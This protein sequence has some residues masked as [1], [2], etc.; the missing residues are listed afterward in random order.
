VTNAEWRLNA[1]QCRNKGMPV[2]DPTN[3]RSTG[4]AVTDYFLK[5]DFSQLAGV[6]HITENTY[7]GEMATDHDFMEMWWE[8]E[9]G[10]RDSNLTAYYS[11]PFVYDPHLDLDGDGWSNFAEAR[12][13]SWHGGFIADLI[14]SYLL[15]RDEDHILHYPQPAIGVNVTYNGKGDYTSKT[16]VVR[17]RTKA[18][19]RVD[20][21]LVAEGYEQTNSSN[22]GG[23]GSQLIGLY[24]GATT[25]HGFMNPGYIIPSTSVAF[26]FRPVVSETLYHWHCTECS[27]SG[28]TLYATYNAHVLLHEKGNEETGE[29][30]VVL[31]STS[32]G[33]DYQRFA[34]SE[35]LA[36]ARTGRVLLESA[37]TT[38]KVYI[39]TINYITGEYSLDLAKA[40]ENGCDLKDTVLRVSWTFQRGQIWPQT[41]WLSQPVSTYATGL[42]KEGK[43]II[44][45]FIDL[46][47]NNLWDE[48]EPYGM[49]K[50]VEI[51]WH[52]TGEAIDI[53]LRDESPIMKRTPVTFGSTGDSQSSFTTAKVAVRRTAINGVS[54]GLPVRTLCSTTAISD[55]RAYITE[56]DVITAARPDLDWAWLARDAERNS[57]T[58]N[59]ATYE[60]VRID[61][62]DDGT[63]SNVVLSAFTREFHLKPAV[64][65]AL[66]PVQS[67]L[68]YAARPTFT[69]ASDDDTMAAYRLQVA[70]SESPDDVI[71]D[72]GTVMLPG[73]ISYTIENGATYRVSPELYVDTFATTNSTPCL[74]DGSNYV[75][76]VALLNSKFNKVDP[77]DSARWSP[78]SVFMMDVRNKKPNPDVQTGYGNAAAAVR[79]YGAGTV[80]DTTT[81]ITNIIVEAYA[82]ADFTGI[83][84]ARMR[85]ENLDLL[86]SATDVT[87]TNVVLRGLP[88]GETFL[89]AFVDSNNNCR[90]DKFES[91]G[92]ANYVGEDTKFI[93]KPKAI[94]VTNI[95]SQFP[96]ISIFIEDTDI[97]QNEFVDIL[98]FSAISIDEE[99]SD[100][101][102][103]GLKDAEEDNYAADAAMWDTDGDGMPDGWEALYAKLDPTLP[104][105][106]YVADDDVMAY[107]VM[108]M[109]IITTWDGEDENSATNTYAMAAGD[110]SVKV[111]D[112]ASAI[113]GLCNVYEYGYR[114]GLGLPASAVGSVYAVRE[115]AEVVLVHGQVYD[116]FGF[117]PNTANGSLPA[118]S[119]VNTKPFSALDK[120][121]V[122]RY[123]E[124]LG[125]ADEADVNR[126]ANWK[127]YT[128]KPGDADCD[129]DGMP[130]GWEL[131]VMSGPAGAS[132]ASTISPWIFDDRAGDPDGDDLENVDEW[133]IGEMP[134]DPW[135]ADTDKDGIND[136]ASYEYMFKY[137]GSG[138]GKTGYRGDAD[139]DQLSN[140]MEYL[141][142]GLDGF[143]A[144]D[145]DADLDPSSMRTFADA[146]GQLVPDY[147]LPQGKLYLGEM[148]TD[149]DMIEDWWEDEQPVEVTVGGV[150]TANYSRYSYD[151]S[152]DTD[153]NGWSNWAEAR[154]AIEGRNS[155]TVL[156]GATTNFLALT[157]YGNR[158]KLNQEYADL[159]NKY[160]E[161]NILDY[162]GEYW[163][164]VE[165]GY[166][167]YHYTVRVIEDRYETETFKLHPAVSAALSYNGENLSADDTIVIKAWSADSSTVGDPDAVWTMTAGDLK[168]A[169]FLQVALEAPDAGELREGENTFV[170]Y[171]TDGTSTGYAVGKPYG[172][173]KGVRVSYLKGTPFSI[174]LTDVDPTSMRINISDAI[175]VQRK[176]AVELAAEDSDF[177][178][179]VMTVGSEAWFEYYGMLGSNY[180]EVV[181]S[182]ID[183]GMIESNW[184]TCSRSAQYAGTNLTFTASD[185]VHIWITQMLLNGAKASNGAYYREIAKIG[186][187]NLDR[188]PVLTEAD[189]VSGQWFDLGGYVDENGVA[190]S[191]IGN[192]WIAG[193]QRNI[194]S[195]TNASFAIILEKSPA[196]YRNENNILIAQMVNHYDYGLKQSD[197]TD[198]TFVATGSQ[199]TF[200]WKHASA[201][202]KPYP[203][204]QLKIWDA[205]GT[206]VFDS[207]VQR[208]PARGRDGFYSW[209]APIWAGSLTPQGEVF[210]S[211]K[212]YIWDVSMLDAK[213]VGFNGSI[214]NGASVRISSTADLSD[215]G[216]IAVGVKYMGPG[217][218]NVEGAK[219]I[220]R[221]EAY[222]SP[223]FSGLPVAAGYVRNVETIGD[224]DK[225]SLNA[226][227]I[228]LPKGGEYYM[229]AYLDSNG[230]GARQPY[231]SWGYGCY[232]GDPDR[233]DVYTPRA[234][235]VSLTEADDLKTTTCVIYIEDCDTNG[236]KLPDTLELNAA[237]EFSPVDV[238]AAASPYIVTVDDDGNILAENIY[239]SIEADVVNL[240]YYSMLME[241]KDDGRLATPSLALAMAGLTAEELSALKPE[242]KVVITAF[243]PTEGIAIKVDPSATVDGRTLEP[244]PYHITVNLKFTFE[245]TPNL[246][247]PWTDLVSITEPL[248]IREMQTFAA[249]DEALKDTVNKA[250]TDIYAEYPKAF[251][252]LKSVEVVND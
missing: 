30:G 70:T 89:V 10:L 131:Y 231:E 14:D 145:P 58:V 219:G 47:L 165:T 169:G 146:N 157:T 110:A 87:T 26:D 19:G 116:A 84:L 202:G 73:R 178:S 95:P 239:K 108:N 124:A 185:T 251:F 130:D 150:R 135:D 36:N 74:L 220:I 147:F 32:V 195:L 141:I 142:S 136:R 240:P 80:T 1:G 128:L 247:T 119:R 234:Y 15:K 159:L 46:N 225:I 137:G 104:D 44:E 85:V 101:D 102:G 50:D 148:F 238:E 158:A 48:G 11:N 35:P 111:G 138:D 194:G 241:F 78:W 246:A 106:D 96:S 60:V 235:G 242:P 187:V 7:L 177:W 43:N 160:G 5:P 197:T 176:L 82:S 144:T 76:R 171:V 218:V 151:A 217:T 127:G 20:A 17:A 206:L 81:S 64:P 248:D 98:E 243:S 67:G 91:W 175:T 181:K 66:A 182:C 24:P 83:P 149:H 28:V 122:V 99:I 143:P 92:Y 6:S 97:N 193:G 215:Y 210:E 23:E 39:G 40:A 105:A 18:D 13:Y 198:K 53:E 180:N 252:R 166:G 51:G 120:Y 212:E 86:S 161:D 77:N 190:T 140:F 196:T 228:G 109:T 117:N 107:A 221:V 184:A 123:L 129:H 33:N 233:R 9:N 112:D 200:M 174:E 93:Y 114:Y 173:V 34:H 49:V 204:F 191:T 41:V 230:D 208:S 170:A 59:N 42:V 213:F 63:K 168:T 8:R 237:G 172:S 133:S 205:D 179:R 249:D 90:R 115:N 203:A 132:S 186:P 245:W 164:D 62:F 56:A 38:N 126:T 211:D 199:P 156:A 31:D 72:S 250:I 100:T 209:T 162:W 224:I 12:A 118:E 121:L 167:E 103:D 69:F 55:D 125:L 25:L 4:D 216:Q 207:G 223:D 71:W 229:L 152:R 61:T 113:D 52:K 57:M 244:G 227:V 21:T 65:T 29:L 188:H 22:D 75:W 3:P 94:E 16:L 232:V 68:V 183:R 27:A 163:G 153:G 54:D 226:L 45:A 214:S 222:S 154:L 139:N 37:N 189:M 201:I 79:Y 236:N 2:L 155:R 88:P 134:T 192:S